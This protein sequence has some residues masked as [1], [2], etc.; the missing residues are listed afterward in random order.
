MHE[1]GIIA[2]CEH[3]TSPILSSQAGLLFMRVETT[4]WLPIYDSLRRWEVTFT[5]PNLS[6]LFKTTLEYFFRVF[7][8]ITFWQLNEGKGAHIW[9]KSL[10]MFLASAKQLHVGLASQV[11]TCGLNLRFSLFSNVILDYHLTLFSWHGWAGW[12]NYFADEPAYLRPS[13]DPMFHPRGW[14]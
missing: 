5:L 8:L 3:V 10:T 6:S 4:Y 9:W 11:R 7:G 14:G 12:Y 1:A 13:L 2:A